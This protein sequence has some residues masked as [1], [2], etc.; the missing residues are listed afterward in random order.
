MD[1]KLW[2]EDCFHCNIAVG[3]SH[4][5]TNEGS[6]RLYGRIVILCQGVIR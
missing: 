1:D 3:D 2:I 5:V 6:Q 4:F